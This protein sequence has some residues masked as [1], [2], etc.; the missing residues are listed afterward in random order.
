MKRIIMMLFVAACFSFIWFYFDRSDNGMTSSLL[1]IWLFELLYCTTN[2]NRHIILV[3][4]LMA[5]FTFLMGRS[6]MPLFMNLDK[7]P[8]I[9][10]S[11]ATTSYK[12]ETYRHLYLCLF[13]SLVFIFIG[14]KIVERRMPER[15]IPAFDPESSRVIAIRK[16]AKTIFLIS[17][18]FA[19]ITLLEKAVYVATHG[20]A[21]IFMTFQ[22]SLPT[23]AVVLSVLFRYFAFLYLA[24]LPSRKEARL[25][26]FIYCVIEGLNLL[27]GDR[28]ECMLSL[29][30]VVYY[31]YLRNRL[32][33]SPEKWIGW[34]S[35]LILLSLV[36]IF[37]VLLFL[38]KFFRNSEKAEDATYSMYIAGFFYQ[39]S[40]SMNV[41]TCTYEDY[42]MLPKNK[43]YSIG[44][45]YD[46]FRNNFVSQYL[47]GVK[48]YKV[49]TTELAKKG[50]SLDSAITLIELPDFF[51]NGGGMGSSFI[52]EAWYDMGYWGIVLYSLLYG[53]VIASIPK[54]NS[55]NVWLSV[56][57]L[58]F[59]KYIL[60]APRARATAFISAAASVS[61]WPLALL[62]YLL[63]YKL[64]S[65][66]LFRK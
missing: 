62:I 54:W 30:V 1:A 28:G 2:I 27:G 55:K 7:N 49:G 45:I 50:H 9:F 19:L 38:V 57:A 10:F 36:P 58:V 61:F 12:P 16:Y 47:F 52:A 24:T 65:R 41:I 34:R 22:S 20:Y 37:A 64:A 40:T 46:Y 56:I 63:T 4:F 8:D 6:I 3:L 53:I 13:I 15:L 33:P 29:L 17:S 59:L 48:P 31:Y 23:I 5:F 39:Q 21:T 51:Y 60:Y 18:P 25:V 43:W 42:N 44:P 26:V 66:S 11:L 32:F 14:Y 35:T